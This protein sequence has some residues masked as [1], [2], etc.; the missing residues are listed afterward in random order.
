[1]YMFLEAHRGYYGYVDT[2]HVGENVAAFFSFFLNKQYNNAHSRGGAIVCYF[3]IQ[4][5]E[6]GHFIGKIGPVN[7]T[8]YR[9]LTY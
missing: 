4:K 6:K 9:C 8:I 1:M 3:S 2:H 5:A 7:L